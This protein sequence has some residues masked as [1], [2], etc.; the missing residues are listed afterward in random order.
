M[1]VADSESAA[2]ETAPEVV[3]TST[4]STT[5]VASASEAAQGSTSSG[6]AIPPALA[7][8]LDQLL[9][10]AE[11]GTTSQMTALMG[12]TVL[13]PCKA[14]SLGQRTVSQIIFTHPFFFC[15]RRRCEASRVDCYIR[16]AAMAHDLGRDSIN[17]SISLM[18][19][20]VPSI[21]IDQMDRASIF[22]LLPCPV[23]VPDWTRF[24][25]YIDRHK[26][27]RQKNQNTLI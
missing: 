24:D 22:S 10:D 23:L 1:A 27:A 5:E 21:A 26:K 17:I 7:V 18:D 20:L 25:Y 15:A 4:A 9:P 3:A 8:E 6:I 13:L 19:V 12:E 2:V 11:N 14:Y 16:F